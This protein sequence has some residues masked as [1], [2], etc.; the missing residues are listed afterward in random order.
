MNDQWYF[1]I[2]DG[3]TY[4]PFTLEKLRKWA[5]SGNLMPTHRVRPADSNEWT[6]A[7]Y[8][9]GLE[10]TTADTT[11]VAAP[12]GDPDAGRGKLGALLPK[13][14]RKSPKGKE[15]EVQT[16]DIVELCNELMEIAFERNASDIHIDPEENISLVQLRV[17]GIL[18]T[19]RKFPKA[20]HNPIISRFKILSRMD[21]A[22]RR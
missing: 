6:I 9:P 11:P 1:E 22:E 10:L 15:G 20:L 3:Q 18:E 5:A 21:I 4:G 17:D 2:G 7:A 12:T 14:A 19:L 16:A 13:I 8:V